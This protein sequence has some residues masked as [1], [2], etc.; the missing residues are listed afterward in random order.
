MGL[1]YNH[2]N[3]LIVFF[4]LPFIKLNSL[5]FKTYLNVLCIDYYSLNIITC[6]S[7]VIK[8]KKNIREENYGGETFFS[9]QNIYWCLSLKKLYSHNIKNYHFILFT[10]GF[11]VQWNVGRL[12][13]FFSR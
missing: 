7:Y 6:V 11:L 13:M 5:Y 12:E 2:H 4:L 8:Y 3:S 9:Q 10:L 1:V